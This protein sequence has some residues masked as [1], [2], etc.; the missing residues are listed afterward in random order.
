MDREAFGLWSCVATKLALFLIIPF[1][2]RVAVYC[3]EKAETSLL[4][5]EAAKMQASVR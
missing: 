5:L 4:V 3:G 2:V 1:A